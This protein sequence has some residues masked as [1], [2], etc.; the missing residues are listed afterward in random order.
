MNHAEEVIVRQFVEGNTLYQ[1]VQRRLPVWVL[2]VR[3]ALPLAALG[4]LLLSGRIRRLDAGLT[5]G[6]PKVSLFWLVA[7]PAVAL[8]AGLL[9]LPPAI[10]LVRWRGWTLPPGVTQPI[11][12]FRMEDLGW[13]V[14]YWCVLTPLFEELLYRAIMLPGLEGVGG[15]RLA[16]L[17]SGLAWACLHV[18][19]YTWP[20]WMCGFYFLAGVLGAWIFLKCRSLVVVI[21]LHAFNNLVKPVLNDVLLLQVPDLMDWLLGAASQ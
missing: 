18:L 4:V 10:L 2:G 5:L 19:V 15:R 13:N 20:F 17:G 12:L 8:A 11:S 9:L 6:K 7:P 21:L 16:L 14:M 3:V 1:T